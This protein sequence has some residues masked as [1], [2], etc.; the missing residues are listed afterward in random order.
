[1]TGVCF[2]YIYEY[3]NCRKNKNAGMKIQDVNLARN[4]H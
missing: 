3:Q 4:N 2:F 1:M